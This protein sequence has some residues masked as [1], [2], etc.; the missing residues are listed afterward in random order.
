MGSSI[1]KKD[2]KKSK[3]AQ[4]DEEF[5][6]ARSKV[7]GFYKKLYSINSELKELTEH[8]AIITNPNERHRIGIIGDFKLFN[9]QISF[10]I[11]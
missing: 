4:L 3:K 1:S 2:K 11:G 7:D 8:N 9:E 5:Q 6:T 10:T